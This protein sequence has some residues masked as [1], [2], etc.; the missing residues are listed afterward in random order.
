ML[1]RKSAY[2][3][4]IDRDNKH[5]G[6]NQLM[7]VLPHDLHE[8][9]G[10]ILR[11]D[12]LLVSAYVPRRYPSIR[13]AGMNAEDP[14]QFGDNAF[15]RWDQDRRGWVIAPAP[16]ELS[17][18]RS[19]LSAFVED[20]AEQQVILELLRLAGHLTR[21]A[22]AGGPRHAVQAAERLVF[23]QAG[24]GSGKT[25]LMNHLLRVVAP[26]LNRRRVAPVDIIPVVADLNNYDGDEPVEDLWTKV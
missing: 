14:G 21:D 17:S 18:V 11:S 15:S 16:P 20:R 22:L 26:E 5:E 25:T 24:I 1:I 12:E 7:D 13:R 9:F 2:R 23:L 3:L 10:D 6:R 8:H 4:C 19:A